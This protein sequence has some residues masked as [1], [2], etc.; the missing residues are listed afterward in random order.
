MRSASAVLLLGLF[1]A[2][3]APAEAPR[4]N[5][6]LFVADGLRSELVT[7]QSAPNISRVAAR[8]VRFANSHAAYPTLSMVNAASL[9]TGLGPGDHGVYGDSVYV[10]A[11]VGD[12]DDASE[13]PSL[14]DDPTL[15]ALDARHHALLGGPTLIEGAIAAGYGTAVVGKYGPAALMVPAALR[16]RTIIIDDRTGHTGGI[17]VPAA[18]RARLARSGLSVLA[19]GRG[20]NG[21]PGNLR[22]RGTRAA[23]TGQQTWFA[24]VTTRAVLPEL[25]SRHRPFLL[26]YWSRDPDGTEHNHGDSTRA[27]EPGITGPTVLAAVRDADR[28][29][30]ELL[31]SLDA[32]GLAGTT[33]IIIAGDHGFSTVMH[34][35]TTSIAAHNKYRGVVAGDTPGGYVAIDLAAALGLKLH[36][37]G[38]AHAPIDPT[39]GQRP[40]TGSALLG[41]DPAAPQV[42][43][44]ANGGSDLIYVPGQSPALVARIVDALL[45]QD[46]VSGIFVDER[47]G[48]LP[49]TLPLGAVGLAGGAR[50]PVPAIV[51]SLRSYTTGCQTVLL[52]TVVAGDTTLLTGQGAHGSASRADTANYLAVAGPDFKT[53]YVDLAP[54]STADVARTIAALMKLRLRTPAA[55]AGRVLGESFN[56]G[57]DVVWSRQV[58]TGPA[59]GNGMAT[60][61]VE[62]RVGEVRYLTAG[63]YAGRTVGLPD[64]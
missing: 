20:E 36:E 30:G 27:V 28:A 6:V 11:A 25:R 43:V 62:Q 58:V 32:L 61:I 44:A 8:G 33:D 10:G 7:P 45:S 13:V 59:A 34:A 12:D 26:V 39:S 42:V 47:F 9:A 19:P 3:R 38:L 22:E 1:A 54:A 37:P 21:D 60:Q 46:Y 50:L 17:E 49:G 53:D 56:G 52:C 15:A 29:L 5:V 64:P 16:A 51:V 14:E 24:A 35:S 48:A 23:N 4:H 55:T 2:A 41:D 63:G 40:Q 18:M 31:D 57:A